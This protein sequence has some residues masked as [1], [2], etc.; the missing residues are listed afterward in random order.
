[1]L[2]TAGI[3]LFSEPI[4]CVYVDLEALINKCHFSPTE[5]R[6]IDDLMY[7]YTMTDVAEM[8]H[9]TKQTVNSALNRAVAKICEENNKNWERVYRG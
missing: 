6:I 3:S 7:G 8:L 1:M 5:R 4:I 2:E 9:V